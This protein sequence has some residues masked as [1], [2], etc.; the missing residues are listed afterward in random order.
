MKVSPPVP[1]PALAVLLADSQVLVVLV[2]R[3]AP[4]SRRST[5]H[6]LGAR[7]FCYH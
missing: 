6:V 4:V 2:G 3:M 5:K 1:S 7:S